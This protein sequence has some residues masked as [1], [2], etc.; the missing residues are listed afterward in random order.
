MR[1]LIPILLVLAAGAN[2]AELSVNLDQSTLSG[3][4]GQTLLFTG[5]LTNNTAG[6]LFI[7]A[8]SFTFAI[9]GALDDSPF[10]NNAPFSIGA[11]GTSFDFEMFDVN[12][13]PGQASGPYGGVFTVLG[14]TGGEAMD[15]LGSTSF[16][17]NVETPEP[18]TYLLFA[19]GLALLLGLAVV[20]QVGERS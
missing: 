12:I 2:A 16:T 4:P 8:D 17:A 3:F 19:L 15:N 18:A 6:T 14:G 5:T 11:G 7:N 13:P 20:R 9:N 1:V 10:L